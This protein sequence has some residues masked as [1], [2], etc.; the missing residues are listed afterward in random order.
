MSGNNYTYAVARIRAKEVSLFSDSVIEQLM[1]CKDYKSCMSF[2]RE[3]GWGNGNPEETDDEMLKY[4]R[5]KTWE[6]VKELAQDED[7]FSVLTIQNE[8]HNLKAAIKQVCSGDKAQHAYFE[9]CR[10]SAN[11]L[12]S[13]VERKDFS[14]LTEKMAK[15]AVEATETLLQT[16]DGQLCDIIIDRAALEAVK[17]EGEKSDSELIRQYAEEIVTVSDIRIA[18]RCAKTKKSKEFISRAIVPCDFI[19]VSALIKSAEAGVD[20]VC[21][22]LESTG[23]SEAAEH[24]KESSSAFERWCDNRIIEKIKS[25]KYN[26]FSVG[27]I[28]AYIIARENEIKTVRIILTGKINN[29]SDDFIRERLR[30][31]YV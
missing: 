29:L 6:E 3:H 27:P 12:K 26:S 10:W 24:I 17:E 16:D 11:E 14:R 18:V 20:E 25:Q 22:Y 30:R 8:Y 1:A 13:M 15:V 9:N 2:L 5:E 23:Y 19:N 4:E 28:L 21:S 31:M 7:I